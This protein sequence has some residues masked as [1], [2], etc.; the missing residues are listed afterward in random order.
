MNPNEFITRWQ[1]SGGAELA[2]SQSF[3][4]ELCTVLDVAHPDPTQADE[5]QNAYVFEKAV[6]F[7]NGDGTFSTGR[8]DLYRQKCFILEYKQGAERKAEEQAEALATVTRNRKQRKGTAARGTPQWAQAMKGAFHQAKRY[9]EP[10]PE[11]PPFLIVCDVG[12]CI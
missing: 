7:N 6:Q 10:L 5:S 3:L 11:W 9:A 2:N 12:H 8:I 4:K 1:R